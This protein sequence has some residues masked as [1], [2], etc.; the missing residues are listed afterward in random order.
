[1]RA[2]IAAI[3]AWLALVSGCDAAPAT[4]THDAGPAR[5]DAP[6]LDAGPTDAGPVRTDPIVPAPSGACPTLTTSGTVMASPAGI[7]P[8]PV[9]IFVSDA[10][11]SADGPVVFFWHGA[12]GSPA[13]AE[14]ALG[15]AAMTAIL[16]AGGIVIAPFHDP[17]QTFLPWYLSLGDQEDDLLVADEMLGC[18]AA[19]IG[20]DETH[21]HA[22]GFSAGALH[23]TKMGFLR[24]SYVASVVTYSGGLTSV[25]NAPTLDAP[26]ARFAAMLLHG[27]PSDVVAYSFEETTQNYLEVARAGGHFAFVCDHGM[28]HTVPAAARES[29]WAFLEAHAY[30]AQPPPYAAGLPAGFYAPCT[31]AP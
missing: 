23:T 1:M 16:E 25:R 22:V 20:F 15:S 10:A 4:P 27:G 31:L 13:E 24:A 9:Q 17:S 28:G 11:A 30:G 14:Y 21:V 19:S 6:R 5:P 26:D 7:A 2:R 18:A 29:A 8:R 12:G 3:T